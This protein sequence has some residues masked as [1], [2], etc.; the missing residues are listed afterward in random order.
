MP[1]IRLDGKPIGI[2]IPGPYWQRINQLYQSFKAGI[3]GA[4]HDREP[5]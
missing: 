2:G 1:V 5:K 3:R 4:G